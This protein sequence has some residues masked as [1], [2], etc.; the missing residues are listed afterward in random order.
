MLGTVPLLIVLP[1]ITF[2][3]G[4]ARLAQSGLVILFALLTVTIATQ[5]AAQVVSEHY[6]NFAA[7]LGASRTQIL[8]S[9][10]L[11]AAL[12]N[13]IAAVRLAFA[14][15]WGWEVVVE[16]LGAHSGLGLVI[17]VTAQLAATADLLAAVLT[18]AVVALVF[19]AVVTGVGA[20]LTRWQE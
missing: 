14:A 7:C 17:Q 5:S 16:Q 13:V 8:R 11:P 19:D 10:V 12:P 18:L 6:A 20:A 4:T 9:V 15:G 2:W 3:F 1:F